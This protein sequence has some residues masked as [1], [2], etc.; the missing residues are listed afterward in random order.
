MNILSCN[1]HNETIIEKMILEIIHCILNEKYM[2]IFNR[3]NEDI[4]NIS[5]YLLIINYIMYYN[6]STYYI[7]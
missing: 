6:K 5:V 7:G 2:I 4:Q 3:F 1:L